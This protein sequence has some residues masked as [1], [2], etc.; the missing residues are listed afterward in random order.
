MKGTISKIFTKSPGW[1]LYCMVPVA[2]LLLSTLRVPAQGFNQKYNIYLIGQVTN[3]ITGA[4]LKEHKVIVAS[5]TINEPGFVYSKILYT[6]HEGYYYDTIVT[7]LEKGS[8]C[9]VTYDYKEVRYEKHIHY[10]FKW[11]ENNVLFANFVLPVPPLI[12]VNQ[13][14]FSFQRNPS[15]ENSLEYQFT[16]IT[17]AANIISWKW[18]F[19]DGFSSDEQNPLHAYNTG[20]LYKVV[21][22]VS[23][24]STGN[25]KPFITSITKIINVAEQT[26]FHLG[27]HVFAGYFPIDKSE[28]FL[29][30]IEGD[31]LIPIDTAIFND[32][33]GYY[34]FYQLIEGEYIVKADLHPES[35]LFNQFMTTYYSDKLH[36]DEADTIFHHTTYFQYDINL[37]PNNQSSAYGPGVI[38]GDISYDPSYGGGK[39]SQ[40]AEN[41][42]I[43][44]FDEFDQP[45]NICHSDENG[46]FTLEDLDLQKYYVYAEV[47][48]KY[49]YPV[50]VVLQ[51]SANGAMSIQIVIDDNYVSGAVAPGISENSLSR[52]LGD[53]YPNPAGAVLSL[54][55]ADD[56]GDELT[57][58]ILNASGQ[59]LN[60]GQV[61]LSP[62]TT[63]IAIPVDKL[64]PGFYFLQ[65]RDLQQQT[66]TKK[67][68]KD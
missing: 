68:I 12:N 32:T 26:Y 54:Q 16:D 65:F 10:R 8:L 59:L 21:L 35:E 13:A 58:S 25:A 48:G 43:L 39:A 67:F 45:A 31:D 66:A 51:Q 36:W 24:F 60:T 37:A 62:G 57:F 18:D 28:V 20:G 22:T 29:Y 23:I 14:N 52:G 6:D 30:K 17:G 41:V 50:E 46:Q 5:D 11:D 27:G 33:L 53:V 47:T 49:T 34:L 38:N 42:S 61:R 56:G 44:L 40:P 64:Q 1:L 7:T 2:I 15:G 3:D 55:Y 63:S 9:V 4:P 19:G